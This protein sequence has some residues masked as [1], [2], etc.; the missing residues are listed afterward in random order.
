[1][2]YMYQRDHGLGS[3]I[4]FY[5]HIPAHKYPFYPS[6]LYLLISSHPFILINWAVPATTQASGLA[7]CPYFYTSSIPD[8][9]VYYSINTVYGLNTFKVGGCRA[10]L[11]Y[12]VLVRSATKPKQPLNTIFHLC[13]HPRHLSCLGQALKTVHQNQG[14]KE[15]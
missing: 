9:D 14:K 10:V 6:L 11:P 8:T 1:M 12:L 4:I 7:K 13:V 2:L 15:I 3:A 5:P